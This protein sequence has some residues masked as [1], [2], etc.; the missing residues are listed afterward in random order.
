MK[1]TKAE[2]GTPLD[3][4]RAF[5]ELREETLASMQQE[6]ADR[7][8]RQPTLT[9]EE[10]ELGTYYEAIEPQVR[11]AVKQLRAKGYATSASGFFGQDITW[12]IVGIEGEDVPQGTYAPTVD[13][14]NRRAQFIDFSVGF[15]LDEPTL[16]K[17]LQ[18]GAEAVYFNGLVHRVGFVPANPDIHA[19]TEQWNKVAAILPDTGM[20]APP[21][22]AFGVHI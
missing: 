12:R 15:Q 21:R 11:D 14:T 2:R 20:P 17:L 18:T 10:Q 7:I 6:L 8:A 9:A 19:I 3:E 5:D 1:T 16:Q 13:P 4:I 22:Q